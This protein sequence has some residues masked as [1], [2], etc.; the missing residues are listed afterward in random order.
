MVAA[1]WG[2]ITNLPEIVR[3]VKLMLQAIDKGEHFIDV[4]ISLS[5]MDKAEEKAKN[6]KDTSDLEAVFNGKSD[7]GNSGNAPHP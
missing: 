4:R 6:D 5:A 7:P 1:I 3:I 2:V